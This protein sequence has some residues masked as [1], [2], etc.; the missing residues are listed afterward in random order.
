MWTVHSWMRFPRWT[1]CSIV[2]VKSSIAYVKRTVVLIKI[3]PYSGATAQTRSVALWGVSGS[4]GQ[5]PAQNVHICNF[6]VIH[7]QHFRRYQGNN[8]W[9]CMPRHYGTSAWPRSMHEPSTHCDYSSMKRRS[10]A[11]RALRIYSNPAL[12]PSW[13]RLTTENWNIFIQENGFEN[14]VC[15][16][17]T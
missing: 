15:K 4:Y 17:I 2:C 12:T 8:L 1:I 16:M 3:L 11:V 5:A 6:A 13:R 7:Y 14:V 10:P 9:Q